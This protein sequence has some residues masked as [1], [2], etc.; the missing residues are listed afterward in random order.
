MGHTSEVDWALKQPK[1]NAFV[2]KKLDFLSKE[3]FFD[4]KLETATE[5]IKLYTQRKHPDTYLWCISA[6]G[7]AYSR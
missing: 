3:F 1:A 2:P 4:L 7:K 6:A 5:S